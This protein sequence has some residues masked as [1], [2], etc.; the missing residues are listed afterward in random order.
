M[1]LSETTTLPPLSSVLLGSADKSSPLAQALALLF[2]P[3]PILFSKLIPEIAST[4]PITSYSQLI[5]LAIESVNNWNDILKAKFI[6]SHP[7]IGENKDLS[8]LSANEQGTFAPPEV[9]A[10]LEHLN[11]FYERRYPGLLYV[12]FVNGRSR[13]T[14]AQEMEDR[15]GMRHSS[16]GD[17]LVPVDSCEP[18]EVG[19]REWKLELNRAVS[20]VG[21]IAQARLKG[22]TVEE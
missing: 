19:S 4:F 14:I 3:S 15:L 13:A 8:K 20:D 21:R 22:M 18:L 9:Q 7:R 12:T 1:S 6:A 2:E 16:S 10:R 17:E 5:D 11:A